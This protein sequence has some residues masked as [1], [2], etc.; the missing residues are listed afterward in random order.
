[1][2][3]FPRRPATHALRMKNVD[4]AC[5]EHGYVG[6]V[7]KP[8][9]RAVLSRISSRLRRSPAPE[10]TMVCATHHS[11]RSSFSNVLRVEPLMATLCAPCAM[12]G[13]SFTVSRAMSSMTRYGVIPSIG[14]NAEMARK[15]SR[16]KRLPREMMRWK[17]LPSSSSGRSSRCAISFLAR[18][19]TTLAPRAGRGASRRRGRSRSV[20]RG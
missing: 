11:R 13:R 9:G 5:A 19:S 15:S 2:A 3:P 8:V 17:M 7:A 6:E 10:R 1:M 12:A 14:S 4:P 16:A 20:P 18:I